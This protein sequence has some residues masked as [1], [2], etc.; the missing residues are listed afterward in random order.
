M[1]DLQRG[2]NV[3][4]WDHR[5]VVTIELCEL[6]VFWLLTL[7]TFSRK[8][9]CLFLFLF[10]I[11]DI[12]GNRRAVCLVVQLFFAVYVL[13]KGLVSPTAGTGVWQLSVLP[14]KTQV[15]SHV[16]DFLYYC[17]IV[18]G[19]LHCITTKSN[20][21]GRLYCDRAFPVAGPRLWDSLPSNLRQDYLN[22]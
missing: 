13:S 15:K 1:V 12:T 16:P 8:R 19:L 9:V 3:G 22:L 18:I 10:S 6:F 14:Q 4:G 5:I 20:L 11:V 7:W 21:I 2:I 17:F